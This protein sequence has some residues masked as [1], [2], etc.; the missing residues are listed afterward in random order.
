MKQR[1]RVINAMCDE[2][3][4][5]S[6]YMGKTTLQSIYFGGGT[7]SI[8]DADELNLIFDQINKCFTYDESVEITLEANPDDL[9]PEKLALLADS[10]IN[11]LSIGVQS[12]N[13]D[14]LTRLNRSHSAKQAIESIEKAKEMGFNNLTIDMLYG[15]PGQTDKD[16]HTFFEFIDRL[17]IPHLSAYW[18]TIEK[19]TALDHFIKTGTFPPLDEKLGRHHF[20]AIMDFTESRNMEHYE[21]SNYALDGFI[22]KHNTSYWQGKSYLGIGPGAHSYNGKSRSWNIANNK[23]YADLIS[24]GNTA[25]TT[26]QLTPG[27]KYNEYVM[28]GLRTK[29]GV[30]LNKI[31]SKFVEHFQKCIDPFLKEGRIIE[32]NGIYRLSRDGVF[33]A[34]YIAGECFV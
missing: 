26:E 12:L 17:N 18:L 31:E 25:F 27:D 22:S 5:R 30:Q 1:K 21:I 3:S 13:D 6:E 4:M 16:I 11:R 10:P 2:I 28:T 32:E 8:L 15:I 34:D 29:W 7:P 33:F 24:T 14:I 19:R 9:N 23:K 20:S